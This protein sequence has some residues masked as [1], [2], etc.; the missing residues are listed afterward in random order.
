MIVR[1]LE[2]AGYTPVIRGDQIV[3]KIGGISVPIPTLLK[4]HLVHC[5]QPE[6]WELLIGPPSEHVPTP[7]KRTIYMTMHESTHIPEESVSHL[8]QAE[9]VC[10]PSEW[11]RHCFIASGVKPPIYVVNLGLDTGFWTFQH[12]KMEG[13]FVFGVSGRMSHGGSR[14]GI[15][16]AIELWKKT[17]PDENDV[18]LKVKCFSDDPIGSFDYD[19]RIELKQQY[20]PPERFR[21]WVQSLNCFVSMS[22]GEGW[23][24]IQQQAMVTGRPVISP[25]FSALEE[26]MTPE[27]S[28]EVDY[29]LEAG[30]GYYEHSGYWCV[31]DNESMAKQ[32]RRAYEDRDLTKAKGAKASYDAIKFSYQRSTNKLMRVMREVGMML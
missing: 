15:N 8:N 13:K 22:K 17:F 26:F 19:P 31:P 21:A 30:E 18:V 16:E 23:G 12:T 32:M 14:K 27:N 6:P 11:S 1:A 28:F 24:L 3:T 4:K 5:I 2:E 7:G 20:M 25:I 9:V 29:T 10:V